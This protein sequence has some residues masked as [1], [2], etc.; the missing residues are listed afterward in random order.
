MPGRRPAHHPNTTNEPDGRS[1][2]PRSRHPP[3]P[4]H[5]PHGCGK[6]PAAGV[7]ACWSP[8]P[9]ARCAGPPRDGR[10]DR[11]AWTCSAA[12]T[13]P[14]CD[15]RQTGQMQRLMVDPTHQT[16]SARVVEQPAGD[17]T[18]LPG[19][20]IQ[21]TFDPGI[22]LSGP[23]FPVDGTEE[24]ERDTGGLI[25]AELDVELDE[26]P[27]TTVECLDI[28]TVEPDGQARGLDHLPVVAQRRRGGGAG[29]SVRTQ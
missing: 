7:R 3:T 14:C 9:Y 17:L 4:G 29:R 27:D 16:V 8:T 21:V 23:Q 18:E 20:R 24:P 19:R 10:G 13:V 12:S 11:R 6:A 1:V 5:G 26:L 2:W 25:T 28:G 22:A 15:H